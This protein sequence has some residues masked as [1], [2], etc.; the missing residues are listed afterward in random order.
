MDDCDLRAR[1]AGVSFRYGQRSPD[2][3]LLSDAAWNHFFSVLPP[4]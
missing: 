4:W 3:Q 2:P 1:P